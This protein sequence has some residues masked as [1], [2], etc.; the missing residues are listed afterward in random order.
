MSVPTHVTE[1]QAVAWLKLC[2]PDQI[3]A[4]VK[5]GQLTKV[6]E[7]ATGPGQK[8]VPLFRTADVKRLA[9]KEEQQ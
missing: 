5:A 2:G 8:F 6:G 1:I 9:K 4:W 7:F 3:R